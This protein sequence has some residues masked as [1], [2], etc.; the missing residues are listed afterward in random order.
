[1]SG[2]TEIYICRPGQALK[3]G[4]MEYGSMETRAEAEADAAQRLRL[5]PGIAKIAY[6]AVS[7]NGDFRCIYSRNNPQAP[8]PEPRRP[9]RPRKA[10]PRK[11][12]LLRR[13]RAVFEVD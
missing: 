6:Y 2:V 1:M 9:A 10:K 13:I 3:E 5:N 8:A 11:P 4:R 7:D 12:S